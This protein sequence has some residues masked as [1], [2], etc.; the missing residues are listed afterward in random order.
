M[1]QAAEQLRSQV[2]LTRA[3]AAFGVARSSVYAHRTP[4][5]STQR[6][7]MSP[8]NALRPAERE[9][10]WQTLTEPRFVDQT[11][12]EIVPQLLDEGHY[13]GSIRTFY[14]VLAENQAVPERRDI[15]RRIRPAPVPRL[16]ATKPLQVWTWDITQFGCLIRGVALYLY[17][18]LDLFSR[19]IVG[20]LLADRQSGALAEQLL[21]TTAERW[22]ILPGQL[23]VHNDNGAPMIAK[24]VIDLWVQLN[25]TPS[26]SRPHVSNDNP[27]SESLFKTVQYHP[28]FPGRFA[29]PAQATRW[30]RA[31]E[32]WYNWRH[33]HTG[34]GLMTPAAVHFGFAET[35]WAKRQA[36]L[37]Q[38]YATRPERFSRGRPNPP[39]WPDAV[40]INPLPT[41]LLPGDVPTEAP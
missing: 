19:Y 32:R 38:A 4:K 3:C 33:A 34:L 24:P 15:V 11:P 22:H 25:V 36:V 35:L 31:M 13:R 7:P 20:W 2:G 1:I 21:R 26:Y 6:T 16:T 18:I 37:H 41:L 27:F 10:I 39:R 40:H 8:A 9:H 12:Y 30:M 28:T 14:R 29:D 5:T 23:T 17:L